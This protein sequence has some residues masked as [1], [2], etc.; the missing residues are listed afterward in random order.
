MPATHKCLHEELI[1]DHS[2]KIKELDTRADYK[3]QAI[4]E[5]KEELKE[6]N[7]KIDAINENINKLILNSE[8]QDI[9]IEKRIETLETKITLYEQFFQDVKDDK[10]KRDNMQLTLYA[11]IVAVL[12]LIANTIFNFI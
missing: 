10:N 3:E 5:L 4:M 1:Q 6:M 9:N 12:G 7:V 11:L 8:A 2:L